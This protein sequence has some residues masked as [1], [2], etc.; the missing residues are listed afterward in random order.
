MAD[1]FLLGAGVG[2]DM[3]GIIDG[4]VD[5][6]ECKQGSHKALQ[7]S[8]TPGSEH[9][10]TIS[11]TLISP[12]LNHDFPLIGISDSDPNIESE[13]LCSQASHVSGQ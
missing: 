7:V 1:A 2:S 3:D 5:N 4:A 12:H 6:L 13:S 11:E 10:F 8:Y 9:V